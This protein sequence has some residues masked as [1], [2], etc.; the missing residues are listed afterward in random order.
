MRTYV[1]DLVIRLVEHPSKIYN[2]LQDA[3]HEAE[4]RRQK[5]YEENKVEAK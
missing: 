5:I 4:L 3:V 2:E 1:G